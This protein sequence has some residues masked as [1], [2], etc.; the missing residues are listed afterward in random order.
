MAD[1]DSPRP[2]PSAKTSSGSGGGGQ[3]SDSDPGAGRQRSPGRSPVAGSGGKPSS[4]P[5]AEPRPD[6]SERPDAPKQLEAP[7]QPPR[8]SPAS[9]IARRAA[10]QLMELTGKEPESI[11]GLNRT[12][13]GWHVQVEVLEMD[14][15][16]RTTD[17]LALYQVEVDTEGELL[18][19]R[20]Q[21]RYVRGSANEEGRR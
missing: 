16:P 10:Q 12:E 9:R 7:E 11:I 17:L 4:S 18:A 21:S 13:E 8:R 1:N 6:T 19:Y 15:I 5:K 20:R 3:A 2:R 14:R